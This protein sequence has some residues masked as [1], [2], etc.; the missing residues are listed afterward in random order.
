V[1]LFILSTHR[2]LFHHS[3]F[4]KNT[5][6]VSSLSNSQE[7]KHE[8]VS[9]VVA[10]EG[11]I[12]QEA[13]KELAISPAI[14]ATSTPVSSV[15]VPILTYHR[16]RPYKVS[17]SKSARG[18]ITTPEA[19]EKEL[20]YLEENN[21]TVISF[22]DL[23]DGFKGKK[24][25]SKPVIITFDDGYKEQYLYA[26]PLLLTHHMTATFFIYTNAISDYH[27]FMTWEEVKGL[28]EKGMTIGA[29]SQSHPKLTK[30]S[31]TKQQ[32]EIAKS[33]A[34]LEEKLSVPVRY[35]AY[36]YG[37]YNDQ[38]VKEVKESGFNLAVG[39]EKGKVQR[40]ENI[41]TLKRYLVGSNFETFKE[42]L[43]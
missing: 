27:D 31:E 32:N 21:Y 10:K 23:L 17:D 36:P 22:D 6:I 42:I 11:E 26:L 39:L 43:H 1:I 30:L 19:F 14:S 3:Y 28:S 33:K 25:P 24:M 40:I 37:L 18:Y 2:I 35:F 13:T 9:G 12:A 16:I 34:T 8:E 41:Y 7:L 38:V 4:Q 15:A 20:A 29:H 5:D